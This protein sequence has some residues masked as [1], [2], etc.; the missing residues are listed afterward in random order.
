MNL[1][2]RDTTKMI[3]KR[4]YI[5]TLS[6]IVVWC[7]VFFCGCSA[8]PPK[9]AGEL[10]GQLVARELVQAYG[11]VTNVGPRGYV[12]FIVERLSAGAPVR[13]APSAQ[14]I[15]LDTPTLGAYSGAGHYIILTRGLALSLASEGELAFVLA[16]EMAHRILGH[17]GEGNELGD[18]TISDA[19]LEREIAAD[20]YALELL[21]RAGFAPASAVSAIRSVTTHF[22]EA[23]AARLSLN[24]REANLVQKLRQM[25]S[26]IPAVTTSHDYRQFWS[27]LS[28]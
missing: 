11:Q 8:T 14:V 28:Y 13:L 2:R 19:A 10:S 15:L 7:V 12:N 21:N 17:F 3:I 25:R 24:R 6:F 5:R 27:D 20:S 9:G 1:R 18:S 16:H 26:S 23:T 4:R 22:P